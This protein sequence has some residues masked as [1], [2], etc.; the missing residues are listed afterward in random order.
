MIMVGTRDD[1][2]VPEGACVG[3]VVGRSVS[4][5]TVSVAITFFTQR[6]EFSLFAFDR[7]SQIF[8]FALQLH[9]DVIKIFSNVSTRDAFLA[10]SVLQRRGI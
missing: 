4:L 5:I 3:I 7:S 10:C 2:R 9:V 1:I 6:N 8:D